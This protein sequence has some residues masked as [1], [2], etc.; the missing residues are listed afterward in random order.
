MSNLNITDNNN[1]EYEISK[2][3]LKTLGIISLI[4]FFAIITTITTSLLK[5]YKKYVEK[6]TGKAIEFTL[7]STHTTIKK[8]WAKRYFDHVAEW[9][10]NPK[11]INNTYTLTKL[12]N[13]NNSTE[14]KNILN[15]FKDKL[16]K[17][18]VLNAYI[19]NKDYINLASTNKQHY[20]DTN[21]I[22]HKYPNRLKKAFNGEKQFI[23]PMYPN[24]GKNKKTPVMFI[25]APIKDKNDSTI[26]LLS[27][28]LDPFS[29]FS[30]I[31]QTGQFKSSGETY[32]INEEGVMITESRFDNEL[33]K[34]GLLKDNQNSLLNIEIRDPKVNLT[35]NHIEIKNKKELPLSFAAQQLKD[36]KSGIKLDGFNDY[37]GV[38]VIG[39]WLWDN[40]LEI[41]FI[42][43]VDKE[44]AL[45]PYYNSL[46]I[47]YILLVSTILL[48]TIFLVVFQIITRRENKKSKQSLEQFK[49]VFE[50][51]TDAIAILDENGVVDCN[52]ATVSLFGCSN[53]E[54]LLSVD[55]SKFSPKYQTDGTLSTQKLKEF[56]DFAV[57]N[58][59][60]RFEWIHN[61]IN[62]TK[63]FPTE[64]SLT[65]ITLDNK[66]AILSIW[67][68]LTARKA[69]ENKIKENE[70]KIRLLLDSTREG[71]FGTDNNGNIIF[72]NNSINTILGF[73]N[74]ELIGRNAHDLFHHH[75]PDG[76]LYN[77]DD[78]PMNHA[79]TNGKVSLIDDEVLWKK[80][81]TFVN[82]EYSATPMKKD[83]KIIGAVITFSDITQRK[84]AEAEIL[85]INM[86]S[87]NA[88]TLSKSGF[89][90]I[91]YSTPEY[92]YLSEKTA[93]IFGEHSSDNWK[94]LNK[95]WFLNILNNSKTTAEEIKTKYKQAI[96]NE[97]EKYSIVYPYK[98]PVDNKIIWIKSV[99]DIVRDHN[100]NPKFMYGVA[101]DITDVVLAR[102]ELAKAKE[103]VEAATRAKSEFLA[104]M[105]H[106][107]RT[108]M[109]A[110]IG[111]SYLAL[112]TD[113]TPQQFDYIYKIQSSGQ[114][115]LGIINDILDF[116]KIEA[117]KLELDN[118]NFDLE[119]VF[120]DVATIITYKAHEKDLELVFNID[121]NIPLSLIGD[122]LRL[123]QILINLGNNAIKFTNEGEIL[124]SAKLE[125]E[126]NDKVT[127]KFS[128][129]DTGIGIKK[130]HI[131][132]LFESFSQADNST[133]RKFGGTGLGLTI[134]K[135]L[136]ELMGGKIWIESEFGEGS[137]FYFTV[138]I[139]KQSKQKITELKPSIDLR[140]MK[141]LLCDDNKTS[142][143]VLS[144]I[145]T[146][147]S[148]NVT[149]VDSGKKAIAK[150][151]EAIDNPYKLV[152]VDWKMPE[153]NGLEVAE[154][155]KSNKNLISTP[156]IIMVTAYVKDEI[157]NK[158]DTLGLSGLLTKPVS[159]SSLFDTIIQAFG[160]E[161]QMRAIKD[162]HSDEIKEKLKTIRGASVLLVEDNEIN[163]QVAGELLESFGLIVDIANNGKE[164]IEKIDTNNYELI[165]MDLQMPVMDGISAS[166][167]IRKKKTHN[168]LP[169]IAMT[170]DV[171]G[172]IKEKCT[173]AGMNDFIAKPINP[174]HIIDAIIK[175]IKPGKRDVPNTI[176]EKELL[177]NIEIPNLKDINTQEGLSRVNNNAK[178]YQKIL[179]NF[180]D[181]NTNI[182]EQIKQAYK[183]NN[184]ELA[185]RLVHTIK[186][187]SGNIGANNL[188]I[189]TKE[190]EDALKNKNYTS[191]EELLRL[192][193]IELNKVL[194]SIKN[195]KENIKENSEKNI[196]NISED[197][198]VNIPILKSKLD[199]LIVLI[200]DND[201][202]AET[203][204]T[205]LNDIDGIQ[206]Y[207]KQIEDIK[208][209]LGSYDFDKALDFVKDF[210][211]IL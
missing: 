152:L 25:V 158:V 103:T 118:S 41:G 32:M 65:P 111:L 24:F 79:F 10:S 140:N 72:T 76:S 199:E 211:N 26:A 49:V 36:K 47:A 89:W 142:L 126:E 51:S 160:G 130:E 90:H 73:S 17:H 171:L 62:T 125:K 6:D 77:E 54:Q 12:K 33:V 69:A 91:D 92:Y 43:E 166:I 202:D 169:I 188:H 135:T 84:K 121:K 186:G 197:I 129:R 5:K 100:N 159:H 153:M 157:I 4:L 156:T 147:L 143:N 204:L 200:Q 29:S 112:K 193:S 64:V 40:E 104:S 13:T 61:K 192:Y 136:T 168:N 18:S 39:A 167:E 53:K 108:P 94:Y 95:N 170:A 137:T 35:E 180:Y 3:R 97:V 174:K 172:G 102:E 123:G 191:L 146:S 37:R 177:S 116:S 150:L 194:D 7:I 82:V 88:L 93:Q 141:V 42:T 85:K 122:P 50:S 60:C 96:N 176:P 66:D 208:N 144:D 155:I 206:K 195:Y 9:T 198:S 148:F 207:N 68:D 86:L 70:E 117:G 210:K 83:D 162:I 107:I 75:K 165:F 127:I 175:W 161:S 8:V 124:I 78:C 71:I 131:N 101:Q 15:F 209:T 21:I 133:T 106:E 114:A 19:I 34:M 149:A 190:L 56:K 109:N 44:E 178:L 74:K 201:M 30:L 20:N 57:K 115:L 67:H 2:K 99:G 87:N 38:S 63:E 164:A 196:S 128:V 189:S 16:S 154:K 163:Q 179:L 184:E 113:L 22:A 105:S 1:S 58:G 52:N 205:E 182:I 181:S 173:D 28:E 119:K 55:F 46:K 48:T 80:D 145:L 187:V 151:E 23:P 183:T 11:I 59:N 203:K 139:Q 132:K 185:L 134:S 98:R 27:I 81:G 45:K 138:E 31:A 120:F 110:I 14:Q